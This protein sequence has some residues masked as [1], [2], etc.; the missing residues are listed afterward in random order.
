MNIFLKICEKMLEPLT[1]NGKHII[2]F[3]HHH[4]HIN[5]RYFPVTNFIL[6]LLGGGTY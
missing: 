2:S 6:L 4:K 3:N 5:I 1:I